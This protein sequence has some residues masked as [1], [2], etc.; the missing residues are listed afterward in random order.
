M[1]WTIVG[2]IVM[3]VVAVITSGKLVLL[4]K[5]ISELMSTF[6]NARADGIITDEEWTAIF[7]EAD[8]VLS[9][10]RQIAELVVKKQR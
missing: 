3:A 6:N 2:I 4:K 5:E 8:D 10:L 7:K 1:D 9:A